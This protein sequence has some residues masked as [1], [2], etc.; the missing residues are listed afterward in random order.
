ML[1]ALTINTIVMKK[2]HYL[3]EW[4]TAVLLFA[5]SITGAGQSLHSLEPSTKYYKTIGALSMAPSTS[6]A[7]MDTIQ[8]PWTEYSQNA[9]TYSLI[10][11]VYL[12]PEDEAQLPDLVRMPANS[13]D[14]TKAEL[15]Y[16]LSL[17]K[18]RTKEQINRAQYIATIGS[19]FNILNPLDSNFDENRQ[20]LFYIA[21]TVGEWY[22][23]KNF[24]ATTKLLLNCMQDIRVTEFR[25]KW[26][27]K[28]PRPYHLEPTL[29]PLTKVR[30]PSFASG[31]TL[32]A[33]TQ[34]YIFS[35]IIPEKRSEFLS[36]ADEVRWS[37]ELLGIHYPSDNEAS[38]IIAW[39]LMKFWYNNPEFLK[40]MEQARA[41]WKNNN[42]K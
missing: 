1:K 24:P 19:W 22:N 35:E 8:F 17:Q 5:F 29:Q 12:K 21:S 11:T 39:Y 41:E 14:Q 4:I 30:S 26:H 18:S 37:R 42:F 2:T 34:A 32:W 28:R 38:R 6:R 40:D 36:K 27:F 31:H 3:R 25:L 9:I 16:L 20:Q 23:Y 13:S 15:E 10:R 7:W 33:Y